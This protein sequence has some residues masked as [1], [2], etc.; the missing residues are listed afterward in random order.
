MKFTDADKELIDDITAQFEADQ[1]AAKPV[2]DPKDIPS[3]HDLI[4]PEWLSAILCKDHPG[5]RVTGYTLDEINDGTS[6]RRRIFIEYNA[7]GQDAGLPATVFAKG[8]QDLINRIVYG[9]LG[10]AEVETTFYTLLRDQIDIEAPRAHHAAFDRESG[11]SIILLR[12]MKDSVSFCDYDTEMTF[13]RAAGQLRLLARLHSTFH[14]GDRMMAIAGKMRT[15]PQHWSNILRLGMEEFSNKG[16]IAAESVIPHRLF[17]QYDKIWPATMKAVEQHFQL[18]QTVIHGDVHLK[19]WYVTNEGQM[20]LSDWQGPTFG[21]WS[22]DI[23]YAMCAALKVEDR[24]AWEAELLGIY[25]E[26]MREGGVEMPPMDKVLTLFRRQ[27]F[28][29]LA[30]WTVTLRHPP[31][32][33]DMQPEDATVEFIKRIAHAIDDH[34]ALNS[35]VW[36]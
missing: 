12:D 31:T 34:E 23:A 13:D 1:A 11:K 2:I 16:F 3:R 5:T 25:V 33:P 7:A 29:A 32:M 28:T 18:P 24:R 14:R 19:N 8:S 4:T 15:W 35:V 20:G 36:N 21:H 6:N 30:Y 17:S 22:R 26:A 9:I 10:T 27:L